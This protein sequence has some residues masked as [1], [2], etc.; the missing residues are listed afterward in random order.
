M[1]TNTLSNNNLPDVQSSTDPRNIAIEYVGVRGVELP[2]TVKSDSGI[3]PTVAQISMFVALPAEHK[4]THMS[5]FLGLL[6]DHNRPLCKTVLIELM[7]DMLQALE[8]DAG[9]IDFEFPLFVNKQAPV[10]KLESLMNYRVRYRV[11]SKGGKTWVTQT[12]TV[13]V[14]S[15]CPCS[16]E[17]S[18][19]GAHNQRSHVTIAAKLKGDLSLERQIRYVEDSASCELWSRLKRVD[20]KF[21]T[22]KA[23]ENPKFVEDLVRDV[24]GVLNTDDNVEAY[25]VQAENF[26]SIHNH[27]A[28]AQISRGC[29]D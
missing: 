16:K 23:Y 28:Y 7:N 22:E 9:R 3:Q 19:Y 1:N 11:E 26:E 10:S 2:V 14:T 4:G 12:V 25:C 13:P 6:K 20:E 24:A 27:S 29:M 5:R 17:I 18:R 15:L 21:V 8:S